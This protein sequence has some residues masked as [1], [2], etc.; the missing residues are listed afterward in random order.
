M[1]AFASKLAGVDYYAVLPRIHSFLKPKTY[2]EIGIRNGQSFALAKTATA[3][4]GI[5]P[6]PD[7][8]FALRPGARVFPMT[9]DAFFAQHNLTEELGHDTVDLAFIDGMHLFEFA[10][11]DFVNLEKFCGPASTILVHDAYPVDRATAARDRTTQ[12][13][14][15]DVWKLIL[16]LKKYRPD[17]RV[18]TVDVPP[19]GLAIIRGLDRSSTALPSRLDAL[20]EEFIPYE[21]DEMDASKAQQ[22]NRI[23]NK[24][25]EIKAALSVPAFA[26]S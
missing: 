2:V 3:S 8:K 22:L 17:L 14:S 23:E 18:S 12:I 26:A 9:S 11:R 25:H 5:D 16:C 7:L 19:T 13:W 20:C 1:I 15:G 10:L 21:Y 24:W 6:A 4:V